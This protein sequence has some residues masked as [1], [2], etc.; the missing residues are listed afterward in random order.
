MSDACYT[1][2]ATT[3]A[4]VAASV[5][6]LSLPTTNGQYTH[7]AAAMFVVGLHRVLKMTFNPSE[8]GCGME[9]LLRSSTDGVNP[10]A[11]SAIKS[12][13][14]ATIATVIQAS[15]EGTEG[16]GP[17]ITT[18]ADAMD[19]ADRQNQ[20]TQ[21]VI[22]AKEGATA[23]ITSKAGARVTDAILRTADGT[24]FKSIDEYELHELVAAVIQAADRPR[25]RAIRQQL[26]AAI[27]HRFNFRQRFSDN[28]AVLR[29]KNARI[30]AYG[31]I[32]HDDMIANI[33]L[34]EADEAA[35]EE[36]GREIGTAMDKIR[37]QY[38]YDH[39]HDATSLAAMLREL[40]AA[41]AVRTLLD[42]P[43][44]THEPV[45]HAN[46]VDDLSSH[47]R[48]LV[49]DD[50]STVGTAAAA[51]GYTS[52]SSGESTRKPRS[53]DKRGG[54]SRGRARSSS[55]RRDEQTAA[56]NP[57]K[58]CK[59]A[60]RRNRHPN[61]PNDQCFWNK[62]WAG[63]R[64]RYA[65]KKLDIRFVPRDKFTAA[66]GGYESSGGYQSSDGETTSDGE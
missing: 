50:E 60:G 10:S 18:R 45:G 28:V 38:G 56:N 8:P 1:A 53:R 55:R 33:V 64:P 57:C 9:M 59:R 40:A 16:N 24:D 49:F 39:P 41:D 43:A 34:A 4:Q 21:A 20:L 47:V 14:V 5:A 22:G 30:A 26:L 6:S 19:A 58:H 12:T 44:P 31:I 3:K 17:L 7:D 66:L 46:A 37:L 48:R 29:A 27:G 23:A 25:V 42:A 13:N 32:V 63:F 2:R 62:R 61:A 36:W 52:D 15:A 65:C 51:G 54:N 11:L 35:R